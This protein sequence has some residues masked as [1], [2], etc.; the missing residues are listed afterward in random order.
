MEILRRS[1]RATLQQAIQQ[2]AIQQAILPIVLGI[3]PEWV[4]NFPVAK[5]HNVTVN[6]I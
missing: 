6:V 2:Q 4:E 5:K 1:K 3:A